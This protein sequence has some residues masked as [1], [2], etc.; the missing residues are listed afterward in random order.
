MNK[1]PLHGN[2]RGHALLFRLVRVEAGEIRALLW[3]FSYFFVLLCSYYILRPLRDEMGIAGGVEH[4]QWLFTGTFIAML[5]AVPL[6]GWVTSRFSRKQFLPLVYW[7]FIANLLLF[8]VLFHSAP[9]NPWLARA[10]FIWTSVFNL[11]VVSVFWSFL[12]DLF[13][14]AQA[15]RLFGFVAAGGTAGA[16]VGGRPGG[17]RSRRNSLLTEPFQS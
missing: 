5:A 12:A 7:F 8:Y 10:F 17:R 1:Q 6:F 13:D 3:A 14:D 11:F 4:L 9:S 2:S 15:K 16:L